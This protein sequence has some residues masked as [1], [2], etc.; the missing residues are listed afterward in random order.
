MS[1]NAA[2]PGWIKV[3]WLWVMERREEE[4]TGLLKT[5]NDYES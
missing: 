1:Q 2:L 4:I 5:G 3:Y